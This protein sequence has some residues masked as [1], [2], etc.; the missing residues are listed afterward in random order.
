MSSPR[1]LEALARIV[2]NHLSFADSRVKF[3][4]SKAEDCSVRDCLRVDYSPADCWAEDCLE[5][6][7]SVEDSLEPVCSRPERLLQQS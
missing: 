6:D 5:A 1:N 4:R 3:L 7:C 2:P